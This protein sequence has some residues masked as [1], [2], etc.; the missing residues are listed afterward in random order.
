MQ[1]IY[2]HA[3]LFFMFLCKHVK[4]KMSNENIS[5]VMF[6]NVR[7]VNGT[8]SNGDLLNKLKIQKICMSVEKLQ[9]N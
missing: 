6:S 2:Y 7:I 3:L 9:K 4:F 1:G 5:Q 8:T